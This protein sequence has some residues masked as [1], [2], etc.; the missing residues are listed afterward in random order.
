MKINNI[1]NK[2][3]VKKVDDS[4]SSY[5]SNLAKKLSSNMTPQERSDRA[6]KAAQKRWGN[7]CTKK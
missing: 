5:M 1:E 6:K 7:T 2:T 3:P 4:I